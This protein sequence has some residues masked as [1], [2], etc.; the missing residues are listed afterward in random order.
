MTELRLNGLRVRRVGLASVGAATQRRAARIASGVRGATASIVSADV[1][2]ETR[3]SDCKCEDEQHMRGLGLPVLQVGT[4]VRGPGGL[5]GISPE[6][7][8]STGQW[9][10]IPDGKGLESGCTS[11]KWICPRLDKI[12]RRYS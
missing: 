5:F 8:I 10:P 2:A 3:T 9:E 12:R 7:N 1:L 4:L 11:G 6:F